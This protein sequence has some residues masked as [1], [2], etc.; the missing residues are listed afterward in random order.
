MSAFRT[1]A[2]F[3]SA[4]LAASIA[5]AQETSP[6]EFH[7]FGG[8]SY[9]K[10]NHGNFFL[11]GMP[12]GNYRSAEF[13]LNVQAKMGERFRF[14]TQGEIENGEHSAKG[15][16]IFGFLEYRV[17][18]SLRLKAGRV[19]LPFGLYTEVIDVGTLRPFLE[20]PQSIY[21]PIGFAGESYQG[22][23]VSGSHSIHGLEVAYDLYAGNMLIEGFDA[24]ERFLLNEPVSRSNEFEKSRNVLGGHIVVQTPIE[25]LSIGASGYRG[26]LDGNTQ[27]VIA[28]QAE[29]TNDALTIRSEYAGEDTHHDLTGRG[30]YVETSYRLGPR[31]QVAAQYNRTSNTFFHVVDPI[32]PSLLYHKETVLGLNY[33]FT[34][35]L[36]AKM[37]VHHV[38]GNRFAGPRPEDYA[39]IVD[40]GGLKERTKQIELGVNFSF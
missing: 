13:A 3:T 26:S 33:W 40:A 2:L 9:A 6:I 20:A 39:R 12:D 17:T 35:D 29:Y 7:G 36:V 22:I 11:Q 14:V 18:D 15:S 38:N 8:W 25:G 31:W 19:K 5:G 1:G 10:T 23:G 27:R 37:A 21:G 4:L 28:A 24:P 32:A 16:L 34:R 30:W